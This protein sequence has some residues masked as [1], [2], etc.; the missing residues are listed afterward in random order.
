MSVAEPVSGP[1]LP[2]RVDLIRAALADADRARFDAELDQALDT[3]RQTRDL[4]PLVRL[5]ARHLLPVAARDRLDQPALVEEPALVLSHLD[6]DELAGVRQADQHPFARHLDLAPCDARR[7]TSTGP[8]GTT[9]PPR[10]SLT[11]CGRA[12]P[13]PGSA[14]AATAAARRRRARASW[15]PPAAA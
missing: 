12:V 14:R 8:G 5:E 10:A 11:P 3:A 15:S 13:G 6:R 1:D 7:R 2:E 4:K 9:T